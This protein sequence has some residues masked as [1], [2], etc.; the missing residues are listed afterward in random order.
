MEQVP[1]QERNQTPK[2][3]RR[4]KKLARDNGLKVELVEA[5][6]CRFWNWDDDNFCWVPKKQKNDMPESAYAT[7]EVGLDWPR[8]RIVSSSEVVNLALDFVSAGIAPHVNSFLAAVP[9]QNYWAM[10][11]LITVSALK[12]LTHDR[13]ALCR[14]CDEI[15]FEAACSHAAEKLGLFGHIHSSLGYAAFDSI[16]SA[17]GTASKP[18]DG[19]WLRDTCDAVSSLPSNSKLA[20]IVRATAKPLGGNK[21]TRSRVLIALGIAGVLAT[22]EFDAGR[23]FWPE[24]VKLSSHFYSNEWTFPMNFWTESGRVVGAH[25]L[26]DKAEA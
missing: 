1:F 6:A 21:K 20:D 26:L 13:I 15:T 8:D 10:S 11:P 9:A 16:S 18:N 2:S 22:D 23:D 25:V 7:L 14:D 4:I 5:L 3:K 24:K 12:G 17:I 19:Q